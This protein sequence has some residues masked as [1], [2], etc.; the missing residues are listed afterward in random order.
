MRVLVRFVRFEF[1]SIPISKFIVM[2]WCGACARLLTAVLCSYSLA[3]D[4]LQKTV[5]YYVDVV[6]LIYPAWSPDTGVFPFSSSDAGGGFSIS[7]TSYASNVDAGVRAMLD[8]NVG[9][10]PGCDVTD[11]VSGDP[12]G[13]RE[14][15]DI[16][17]WIGNTSTFL[18]VIG[19]ATATVHRL[20]TSEPR[21]TPGVTEFLGRTDESRDFRA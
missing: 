17:E 8:D 10:D 9:G 20:V 13:R 19:N 7:G 12:G 16:A 14:A 6:R 5:F 2:L 4:H 15:L 21:T 1:G 3:T 18:H 11:D